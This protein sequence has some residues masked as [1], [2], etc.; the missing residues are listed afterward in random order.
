MAINYAEKYASAIDERFKLAAVTGPAINNDYDFVGVKT[1][2]VYSIPTV[3]M[4]NYTA[5]GNNRYGNPEELQDTVQELA[6]KKDRSFT[7]TIDKSNYQDTGM[8]K[9][10]GKALSRQLDE[11]VIPEVDIYRLGV[12]AAGAKNIGSAAIT[13][14]NAYEAFLDG[15]AALTDE[16]APMGGRIAYVS[17]DYYKFL[18]LD[19]SFIQ[20]S[21]LAQDTLIKGQLG[22]VDGVPIVVVPT[23]YLAEGVKFI[24]TNPIACCA[25]VK[26]AE[27]KIHDNPPG[28]NGWLIEGRIRYDAFVL[29]NK[30][31]AIYVHKVAGEATGGTTDDGTGE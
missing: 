14:A 4:N 31:G 6:L 29:D 3:D 25:P 5:T 8:V 9:D 7:M 2:K 16:K 20:A 26:L 28:I 23:K 12:I 1:V 30:K 21:D 24:I 13:K 18:K 17:P 27:Y 19:P 22:M 15:T 10:A 11:V